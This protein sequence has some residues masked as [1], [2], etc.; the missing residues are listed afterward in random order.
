MT[1]IATQRGLSNANRRRL[2]HATMDQMAVMAA[3][4]DMN[5]AS[6]LEMEQM[7]VA[8]GELT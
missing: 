5:L 4:V 3:F 7:F 1:L 6:I 8:F 2:E